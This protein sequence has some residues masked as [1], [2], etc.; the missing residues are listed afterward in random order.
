MSLGLPAVRGQGEHGLNHDHA[1]A[2]ESR[3]TRLQLAVDHLPK[4]RPSPPGSV[5]PGRARPAAPPAG[6]SRPVRRC[7][8]RNRPAPDPAA[9]T[10]PG[11]TFRAPVLRPPLRE[12]HSPRW[13]LELPDVQFFQEDP[14]RVALIAV[15]TRPG[16]SSTFAPVEVAPGEQSPHSP[17]HPRPATL[18]GA[19]RSARPRSRAAEILANTGALAEPADGDAQAA[20]FELE[21]AEDPLPASSPNHA[22]RRTVASGTFIELDRAARSAD[23]RSTRSGRRP[24]T[25]DLRCR[26]L[27]EQRGSAAFHTLLGHIWKPSDD[28]A[29]SRDRA[30]QSEA[31][32]PSDASSDDARGVSGSR[33][34]ETHFVIQ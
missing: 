7:V 32:S 9:T 16:S 26:G 19:A 23:R 31:H 30:R 20:V 11:A 17:A 10:V 25:S 15:I 28:A 18:L 29:A 14:Q 24:P 34:K 2:Q 33:K 22:V 27:L 1:P 3:S 21:Q 6:R 4:P 13:L 5:A 8:A 12:H